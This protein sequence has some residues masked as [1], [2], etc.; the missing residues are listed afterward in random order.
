M[1]HV[2]TITTI[3]DGSGTGYTEYPLAGHISAIRYVKSDYADGVD[4]V[5][6]GENS[7]IAVLTGTDVNASATYAPRHATHDVTGAASLYAAAGEPVED[8]IPVAGERLK[9]VV[10]SGG[11]TKTGAFHVY[12]AE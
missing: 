6:T 7:G 2:V 12:I 11:A 4:F 3:A 5:I 9:I 8:R 1:R 10:A